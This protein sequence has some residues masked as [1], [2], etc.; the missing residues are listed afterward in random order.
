MTQL[1]KHHASEGEVLSLD[2]Q[3]PHKGWMLAHICNPN[4]VWE[5]QQTSRAGS[6]ATAPNQ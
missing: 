6:Q 3:H 4:I 2:H 1:L 5:G